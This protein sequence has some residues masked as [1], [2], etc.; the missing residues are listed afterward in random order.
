MAFCIT[1]FFTSLVVVGIP[2]PLV[3][4]CPSLRGTNNQYAKQ[5][6]DMAPKAAQRRESPLQP[7]ISAGDSVSMDESGGFQDKK[8]CYGT[9]CYEGPLPQL[10]T[11][12]NDRRILPT[13][14]WPKC[15]DL[16]RS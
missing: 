14:V 10:G 1:G 15:Y 13:S 7:I 8:P 9:S 6:P 2:L 5:D 3:N 11:V 16:A 4:I 12:D